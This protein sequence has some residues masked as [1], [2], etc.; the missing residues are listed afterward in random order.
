MINIYREGELESSVWQGVESFT[1]IGLSSD[2]EYLLYVDNTLQDTQ[3]ATGRVNMATSYWD[4]WT[5]YTYTGWYIGQER[6]AAEDLI[7]HYE[8]YK[9][10]VLSIATEP[11]KGSNLN[12][13]LTSPFKTSPIPQPLSPSE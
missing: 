6:Q 1:D 8:D 11:T 12:L 13:I 9:G 10:E 2:S 4:S 3:N 7:G 5:G